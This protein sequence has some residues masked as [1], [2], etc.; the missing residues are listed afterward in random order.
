M[1]THLHYFNGVIGWIVNPERDKHEQK[2]EYKF[3]QAITDQTEK[4]NR[5]EWASI[6]TFQ[7]ELL[8]YLFAERF[9]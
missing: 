8:S 4:Q 9:S 5:L 2:D 3:T 6:K 7:I 1:W